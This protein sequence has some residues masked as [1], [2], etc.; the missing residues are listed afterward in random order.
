MSF[1]AVAPP[2][3]S[4]DGEAATATPPRS[5]TARRI[6][7]DSILSPSPF[8]RQVTL[9]EVLITRQIVSIREIIDYREA[10][11]GPAKSARDAAPSGG[12]LPPL[13]GHPIRQRHHRRG[14]RGILTP[15]K[16]P[17]GAS[18]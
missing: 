4:A 5:I 7:T 6:G 11:R 8:A 17:A 9:Q 13:Q 18:G 14:L 12:V 10:A 15:G 2:V 1:S 16:S 3:C